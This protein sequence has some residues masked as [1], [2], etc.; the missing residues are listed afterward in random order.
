MESSTAFCYWGRSV[1]FSLFLFASFFLGGVFFFLGGPGALVSPVPPSPHGQC[2]LEF[3]VYFQI[4]AD[5]RNLAMLSHATPRSTSPTHNDETDSTLIVLR[6]CKTLWIHEPGNGV[7][8]D[9]P[10]NKR[11]SREEPNAMS[12]VE[13]AQRGWVETELKQGQALILP[14]GWWHQVKSVPGSIALSLV[15]R[16]GKIGVVY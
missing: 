2:S 3:A 12:G 15:L 16:L 14:K 10:K 5:V 9:L 11:M 7:A 1:C 13:L 6:G 4:D 8:E